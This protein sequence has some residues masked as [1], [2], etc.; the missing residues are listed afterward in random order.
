MPLSANHL[1]QELQERLSTLSP[2]Q[3]LV[4]QVILADPQ[5]AAVA[6]SLSWRP[7]MKSASSS[8]AHA[9]VAISATVA[10]AAAA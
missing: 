9:E 2:S 4:A 10:S 8:P 1:L 3:A 7:S 6:I 5:G